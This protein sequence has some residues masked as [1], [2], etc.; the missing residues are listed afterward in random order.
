[1][2]I[3]ATTLSGGGS[4]GRS[5]S[6]TDRRGGN[7]FR[8]QVLVT[9]TCPNYALLSTTASDFCSTNGTSV[10][11]SLNASTTN[12]PIGTYTVTYN[13]TNPSGTALTATMTVTTA[14]SGTFTATGLILIRTSTI[15]ITNLASSYCSNA[16][17]SNNSVVVDRVAGPT[18]AGTSIVQCYSSGAIN[19]TSGSSAT[20]I[21][22]F[23]GHQVVQE[24]FQLNLTSCTYTPSVA[25]F[26]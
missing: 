18:V 14:G 8:G 15:T 23:N 24:H 16:I 20:I 11:V 17:L 4:G 26:D 10:N 13:R 21:L 3:L 7:G 25:R 6:N 22:L 5:T 1:M 2:E 12:L 19:V 9:Y